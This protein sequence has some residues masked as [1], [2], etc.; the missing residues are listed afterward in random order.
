MTSNKQAE[1]KSIGEDWQLDQDASM[2]HYCDVEPQDGFEFKSFPVDK[3]PKNQ[4]LV[5]DMSLSLS[6]KHVDW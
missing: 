2:L 5:A 6:T 1:K 3:I 4:I